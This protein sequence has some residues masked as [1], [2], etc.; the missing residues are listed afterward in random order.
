MKGIKIIIVGILIILLLTFL[1]NNYKEGIDSQYIN[2]LTNTMVTSSGPSFQIRE[3]NRNAGINILTDL[4]GK[5]YVF[6]NNACSVTDLMPDTS[7]TKTLSYVYFRSV[8][9]P[10]YVIFTCKMNNNNIPDPDTIYF[11]KIER[12]TNRL[13]WE[14]LPPNQP[15]PS[16]DDYKFT[17]N[18]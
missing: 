17:F 3:F 13:Y 9:S 14:K 8:G 2:L 11:Y 5:P 18:F 10:N 15:L 4:Q 16:T 12:N 1:F 6:S 7:T